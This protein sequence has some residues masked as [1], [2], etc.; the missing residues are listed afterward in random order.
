[1]PKISSGDAL[2]AKLARKSKK[3]EIDF[4]VSGDA[5]KETERL[6]KRQDPFQVGYSKLDPRSFPAVYGADLGERRRQKVL[7]DL[8]TAFPLRQQMLDDKTVD[9]LI[10]EQ[11][12]LSLIQQDLIFE[13]TAIRQG[14]FR[15][16]QGL[17]YLHKIRPGYFDRRGKM[18]KWIMRTQERLYNIK[19]N[20]VRDEEDYQFTVLISGLTPDQQ[21]LINRPIHELNRLPQDTYGLSYIPGIFRRA[22]LPNRNRQNMPLGGA[23]SQAFTPQMWAD[24]GTILQ[25]AQSYA[26]G[27]F[28]EDLPAR[29][30]V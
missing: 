22:A 27:I 23:F 17:D 4:D 18:A 9:W 30:I 19:M 14:Y 3:A 16:P 28:P 8:Q 10:K 15:T 26:S 7:N 13:K 6:A 12:R 29:R 1:M 21:R 25:N 20:G 24:N 2:G 5:V 11:D